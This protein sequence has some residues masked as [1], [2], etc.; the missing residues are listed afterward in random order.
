MCNVFL[1]LN[2]FL[3]KKYL[4]SLWFWSTRKK[5][6]NNFFVYGE[7]ANHTF[8]EK[9]LTTQVCVEEKLLSSQFLSIFYCSTCVEHASHAFILKGAC[10]IRIFSQNGS[11]WRF[12]NGSKN[13]EMIPAAHFINDPRLELSVNWIQVNWL[14]KPEKFPILHLFCY[15]VF[16]KY[17]SIS[18]F[19]KIILKLFPHFWYPT[20][21]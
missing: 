6:Q 20:N 5:K 9:L 18:K 13:R 16:A 10:I 12:E 4:W 7:K 15:F 17:K 11:N 14:H 1:S 2:F 3:I 8:M 21:F 19:L